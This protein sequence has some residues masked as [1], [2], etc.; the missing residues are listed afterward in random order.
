VLNKINTRNS[1]NYIKENTEKNIKN[2]S[3]IAQFLQLNKYFLLQ[4]IFNIDIAKDFNI[5]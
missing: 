2:I 5:S 3:A 1:T 4:K